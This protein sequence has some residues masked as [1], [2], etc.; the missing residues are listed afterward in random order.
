MPSLAYTIKYAARV[1]AHERMSACACTHTH[2]RGSPRILRESPFGLL[3]T[4]PKLKMH[5]LMDKLV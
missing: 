1:Y 3:S 5:W 4:E 2:G